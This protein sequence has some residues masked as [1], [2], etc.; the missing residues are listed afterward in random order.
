KTGE[1]VQRLATAYPEIIKYFRH[2]IKLGYSQNY[3]FLIAHALGDFIAHLDGDDIWLPGKLEAQ[4]RFM[5]DHP[6]CSA[7]FTNAI[8]F[9]KDHAILGVYNNKQPELQDINYL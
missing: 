3:Q 6:H 8:V 9:N 7:V 2:E 4:L 1:I 5:K